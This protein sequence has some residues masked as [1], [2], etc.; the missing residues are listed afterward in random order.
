[1]TKQSDL[2]MLEMLNNK[3]MKNNQ[4]TNFAFPQLL[5]LGID[6][7]TR[8]E[9]NSRNCSFKKKRRHT[10][11]FVR[12]NLHRNSL[13]LSPVALTRSSSDFFENEIKQQFKRVRSFTLTSDG[14][15]SD[16]LRYGRRKSSS[17]SVSSNYRPRLSSDASNSSNS[18]SCSSSCSTGYYRVSIMG[19]NGVGKTALKNC[20]MSTEYM[21]SSDLVIHEFDENTL[22]LVVDNEESTMEFIAFTSD[23]KDD[24]PVD[25]YVVVLSVHD[26]NS[27]TIAEGYLQ[28]LR[29]EL[30]SDRPI[31]LVANKVDLVRKRQIT[32]E[33][34]LL[35]AKEFDCKYIET[36]AVLNHKVDELLVGILKQIKLKLNPEAIEKAVMM[37]QDKGKKYSSRKGPKKLLEKLFRRNCKSLSRLE[38]LFDL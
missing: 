37:S 12:K 4:K 23:Q 2:D 38:N 25:A 17:S 9:P 30:D 22:S 28:Y 21:S 1:M 29:N 33:E 32:T 34:A 31:I 19:A 10:H 15:L 27:F 20:F 11:D 7:G 36:S 35:L 14:L 18:W 3:E 6:K 26:S 24:L 16:G 13:P 8:S 5:S